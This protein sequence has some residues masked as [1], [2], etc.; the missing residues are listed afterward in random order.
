MLRVFSS[1][2]DNLLI[3]TRN[4]EN[5]CIYFCRSKV[6][7]K[8]GGNVLMIFAIPYL[9]NQETEFSG[10]SHLLINAIRHNSNVP[11][12][13]DAVSYFP[14]LRDL[15]SSYSQ[16]CEA[17]LYKSDKEFWSGESNWLS[18]LDGSR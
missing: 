18:K 15:Q 7:E 3:C 6:I 16:I 11:Q 5:Q 12:S 4:Y 1:F 17:C 9:R 14:L 10:H 2:F 13:F 8:L